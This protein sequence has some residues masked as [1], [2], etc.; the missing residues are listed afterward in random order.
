MGGGSKQEQRAGLVMLFSSENPLHNVG[1]FHTSE[2]FL[3]AVLLVEELIV[4]EAQQVQNGRV[5]V[6]H[7]HPVLDGGQAEFVGGA[8]GGAA[9]DAGAGHPSAEGV[10]VVVATRLA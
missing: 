3:E 10:L 6:G 9:L 2:F 7:A 5:P 4:V 1:C 8:V